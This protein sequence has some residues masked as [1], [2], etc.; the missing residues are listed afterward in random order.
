MDSKTKI[1]E[2]YEFYRNHLT[3][4]ILP[5]SMKNAIDQKYGG[6]YSCFT[7]DGSQKVSNNKYMW[8]QGR[9]IWIFSKLAE[10]DEFS[11]K[12]KTEF[13]ALAKSGYDFVLTH[14]FLDDGRCVF[15]M[16]EKGGWLTSPSGEFAGSTFADCYVASGFAQYAKATGDKSALEQAMEM[17]ERIMKMYQENTFQ[18]VPFY[19][20]E[21]MKCHLTAMILCGMQQ[22]YLLALDAFEDSRAENVR[23]Q[24]KTL[25]DE[26]LNNFHQKNHLVLE[27]IGED[28]L[29][30]KR[31]LGSYVNTGHTMEGMWF[32]LEWALKNNDHIMI[33]EI[34]SIMKTTFCNGWDPLQG[35]L[36][37]YIGIEKT[38]LEGQ[39]LD[40]KEKEVSIQMQKDCKNKLWWVHTESLYALLLYGLTQQDEKAWEYY[41]KLEQYV[42]E[43][44]PNPDKTIGEWIFL[45][46]QDGSPA[47]NEV[48]GRLPIKDPFHTIRNIVLIMELLKKYM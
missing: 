28:N 15:L 46:N 21:G 3:E 25:C 9:F 10:M 35:G 24:Y 33:R 6:Y 42:F 32:A 14:G 37:Y 19:I 40:E 41:N 12:E 11:E 30:C 13:L 27:M 29:P 43:T 2:K 22:D 48:G 18:T 17:Y 20:P 34:G 1:K 39:L 31:F 5:F 8:S 47:D 23:I 4:T 26:I 38:D 7:N 36:Y 45:R 16:D 44:F